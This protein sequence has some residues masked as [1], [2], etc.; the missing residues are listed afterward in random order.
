MGP[1]DL[2]HM[3]VWS[4]ATAKVGVSLCQKSQLFIHGKNHKENLEFVNNVSRFRSQ[5]G[6]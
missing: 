4:A 5:W 3:D 2:N 1:Q 6:P